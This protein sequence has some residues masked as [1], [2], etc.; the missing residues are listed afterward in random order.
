MQGAFS[1]PGLLCVCV[2]LV[3]V[4]LAQSPLNDLV[5]TELL[6]IHTYL[7]CGLVHV[8]MSEHTEVNAG[9]GF[10]FFVFSFLLSLWVLETELMSLILTSG[11]HLCSESHLTS[12][13]WPL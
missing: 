4:T 13:Q 10:C 11:R 3:T 12:S 1:V 7:L 9:I 6:L 8:P 2:L 5:L